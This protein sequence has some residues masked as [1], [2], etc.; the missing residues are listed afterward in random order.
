MEYRLTGKGQQL[1]EAIVALRQW[2]VAH[3]R[4]GADAE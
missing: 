2:G 4:D 1:R 3:P